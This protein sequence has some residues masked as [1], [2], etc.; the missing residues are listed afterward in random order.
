MQSDRWYQYTLQAC[1]SADLQHRLE[2]LED[3]GKHEYLAL[4]EPQFLLDRLN[5]TSQWQEQ[6]A[7][8]H[9]MC[10]IKQPLPS[11]ALMAILADA[12]PSGLPVRS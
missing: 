8:L 12:D 2:A 11:D 10:Q 5:S 9:L 6:M 4:V 7:I 3:L 1:Q